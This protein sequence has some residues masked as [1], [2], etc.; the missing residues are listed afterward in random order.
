MLLYF[1]LLLFV[2]AAACSTEKRDKDS[3]QDIILNF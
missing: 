2:I 1:T 3:H